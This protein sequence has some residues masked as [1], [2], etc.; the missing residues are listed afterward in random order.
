LTVEISGDAAAADL[1]A[2]DL[3]AVPTDSYWL[4]TMAFL[5]SAVHRV[6]DTRLAAEILSR[7][8]SFSG[9]H[10]VAGGFVL[11]AGPV[12]R[13]LGLLA[14][15]LGDEERAVGWYTSAEQMCRDMATP[16]FLALT[17]FDRGRCTGDYATIAEARD[18]AASVGMAGLVGQAE[19][20][21]TGQPRPTAHQ[22]RDALSTD[23]GGTP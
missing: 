1:A 17:L 9:L 18:R 13:S 11:S 14:E 10:A 7:I 21:L 3:D 8:M 20:A 5:S 6:G 4:P 12:D 19:G 22:R 2:F 16:V 23:T 15:T